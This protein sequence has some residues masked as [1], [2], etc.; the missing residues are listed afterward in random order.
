VHSAQIE[1]LIKEKVISGGMIPKVQSAAAALQNGVEKVHMIG[2]NIQHCLLLEIF[3][4]SG[5]GTEI[6]A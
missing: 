2:G 6:V 5:I 4:N 3:T 1:I